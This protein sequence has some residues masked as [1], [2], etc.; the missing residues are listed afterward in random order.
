[1]RKVALVIKGDR[2]YAPSEIDDAL[3]IKPFV[4]AAPIK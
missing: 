2:A 4:A 3:G 1:V